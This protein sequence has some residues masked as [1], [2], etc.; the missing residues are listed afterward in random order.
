MGASYNQSAWVFNLAI[1]RLCCF[2]ILLRL[3]KDNTFLALSV[4]GDIR[5]M[6]VIKQTRQFVKITVL[7]VLAVSM[8]WLKHFIPVQSAL[9][10]WS[11]MDFL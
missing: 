1:T 4:L 6:L 7:S 8:L 10:P 5:F 11:L 9:F 2:S 3:K